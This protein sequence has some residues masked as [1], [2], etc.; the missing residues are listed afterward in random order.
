MERGFQVYNS[1]LFYCYAV[2][3]GDLQESLGTFEHALEIAKLLEDSATQKAIIR[4]VKEVDNRLALSRYLFISSIW[5]LPLI[6]II[7]HFSLISY[8]KQ[9]SWS[10]KRC[11]VYFSLLSRTNKFYRF[12]VRIT[13]V[14]AFCLIV[15]ALYIFNSLKCN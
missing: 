12:G 6:L 13:K 10:T 1:V 15:Q 2:K 4:A 7:K 14:Y 8:Y 11:D 3:L 9:V 5:Y